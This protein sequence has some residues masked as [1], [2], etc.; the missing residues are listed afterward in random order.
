M[1]IKTY[2]K[3][4]V[5]KKIASIGMMHFLTPQTV[6]RQGFAFGGAILPIP[7][8][9]ILV[10]S[11]DRFIQLVQG[12]KL[13]ACIQASPYP[14]F[15]YSLVFFTLICAERFKSLLEMDVISAV[16]NAIRG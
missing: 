14:V 5:N 12:R 2:S 16:V 13:I 3:G 6:N 10:S 1:H 7:I 11:D 15:G 8:P 9:D 4:V